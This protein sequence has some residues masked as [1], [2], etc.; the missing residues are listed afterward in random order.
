[1]RPLCFA[2]QTSK[3]YENEYHK[4]RHREYS[5]FHG[6]AYD[7]VWSLALVIDSVLQELGR[8]KLMDKRTPGIKQFSYRD[9]FWQD[10][11]RGA[12]DNVSFEGVT[13]SIQQIF[14]DNLIRR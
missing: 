8:L 1:M 9:D 4:E 3:D 11:F 13:V 14:S 6:Y 5:R 2:F 12:M 10:L 7:G